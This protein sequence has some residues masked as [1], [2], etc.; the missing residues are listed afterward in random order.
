MS[1]LII[2]RF[3]FLCS[4]NLFKFRNFLIL[5]DDVFKLLSNFYNTV[6][7]NCSLETLEITKIAYYLKKK[8]EIR[9]WIKG[10]KFT[11]VQYFI[12]CKKY[13]ARSHISTILIILTFHNNN[14]KK[15]CTTFKRFHL[16]QRVSEIISGAIKEKN[17]SNSNQRGSQTRLLSPLDAWKARVENCERGFKKKKKKIV[18]RSRYLYTHRAR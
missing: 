1:K 10:L 7:S 3:N 18:D 9:Y 12:Y 14:R 15:K 8:S 4:R 17:F 5:W 6:F 11:R 13:F 16:E 2:L